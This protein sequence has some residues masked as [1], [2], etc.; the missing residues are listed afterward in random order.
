MIHR[1]AAIRALAGAALLPGAALRGQAQNR[2]KT[3]AFVH[4]VLKPEEMAGPDP[5]SP[6]ARAF[7]HGLRSVGW[8]DGHNIV[9]ERHSAEGRPERAAHILAELAAR[10]VDVIA[11]G[12]S[13]WLREAAQ[14]ATKSI[15]TVALFDSDPVADGIIGS[16]GNPGG[17]LT[18][19][20]LTTGPGLLAKRMQLLRELAPSVRNVACLASSEVIATY[21]GSG[22]ATA[23]PG[24]YASVDDP[25]QF[26]EA[27]AAIKS[28]GADAIVTEGSPIIY[29]HRARI[30]A[31]AAANGLPLA[32]NNRESVEEGALMAYGV[33]A[34]GL[35]ADLARYAD[36]CLH[37]IKPTNL[38]VQQPTRFDFVISN[39]TARALGLAIPAALLAFADEVIE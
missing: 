20:T 38:P 25:S 35:F 2:P 8:H 30:I 34:A 28:A 4:A 39:R 1:R 36:K 5:S 26:D 14:R 13:K 23:P 18:G 7:I 22:E 32:A 17:N 21:R 6:L 11:M 3:L 15:P 12:G 10:P 16:L 29:V 27:F 19:V 33:N 31:Y 37:G 9:I 24:I